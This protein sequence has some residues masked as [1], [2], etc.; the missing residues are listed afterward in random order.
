MHGESQ[1]D[2]GTTVMRPMTLSIILA[3]TAF[4]SNTLAAPAVREVTTPAIRFIGMPA[5]ELSKAGPGKPDNVELGQKAKVL[6]TNSHAPSV[7]LNI[8]YSFENP[9]PKVKR[10]FIQCKLLIMLNSASVT[11]EQVKIVVQGQSI[12]GMARVAFIPTQAAGDYRAAHA[13]ACNLSISSDNGGGAAI[14]GGGLP[15]T[16]AMPGSVVHIEGK[17][18]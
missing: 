17:I 2:A 10:A 5:T 15:F 1:L 7:V 6:P 11:S 8:P 16:H 14:I 9:R 3:T 12:A 18:D 4:A 13:Y